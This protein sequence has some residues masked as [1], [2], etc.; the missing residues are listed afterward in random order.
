MEQHGGILSPVEAERTSF[1]S[2]E[3]KGPPGVRDAVPELFQQPLISGGFDGRGDF[4]RLDP[5]PFRV[6]HPAH[7]L[8]FS[9]PTGPLDVCSSRLSRLGAWHLRC[10]LRVVCRRCPGPQMVPHRL[11]PSSGLV[12]LFSL[13]PSRPGPTQQP[14]PLLD[15]SGDIEGEEHRPMKT[16]GEEHRPMSNRGIGAPSDAEPRGKGRR[17]MG[18]RSGRAQRVTRGTKVSSQLCEKLGRRLTG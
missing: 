12:L 6:G 14:H 3:F 15:P 16:E 5:L 17:P 9:L 8:R 4:L 10:V 13:I 7:F 11:P 1:E 18:R 2:V